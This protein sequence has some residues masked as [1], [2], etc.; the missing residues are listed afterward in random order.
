MGASLAC[1]L[2]K[3]DIY[4]RCILYEEMMSNISEETNELFKVL[5]IPINFVEESIK[6]LESHSQKKM[7]DKA[8][9]DVEVV[10]ENDLNEADKIFHELDIPVKIAMSVQE[11][12]N[13]IH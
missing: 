1:Y 5:D 8:V 3:K 9:R 6:A 13:L 12:S 4:K 7:F 10:T 2:N 11:M